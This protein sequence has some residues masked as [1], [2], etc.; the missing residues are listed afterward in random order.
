M[1]RL[2][3]E[4]MKNYQLPSNFP[5]ISKLAEEVVERHIKEHVQSTNLHDSS[6]LTAEGIKQKL[7]FSEFML[8][9]LLL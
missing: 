6:L 1:T 8:T 9:L 3:M 2:E 4:S 5:F 7:S